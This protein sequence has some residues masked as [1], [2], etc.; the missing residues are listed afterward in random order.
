MTVGQSLPHESAHL[1]VSGRATYVD[2]I[3]QPKDCL[4]VALGLSTQAHAKIIDMDLAEVRAAPGV[5]SVLTAADIPGK[6][7]WGAITHDDPF[8]AIDTVEFFGQAIFMVVARDYTQARQACLLAKIKYE[9][10]TPA[11]TIEQAI[12]LQRFLVPP[13]KLQIGDPHSAMAQATHRAKGC[14]AIGGQEH[15]YL[16]GQ[17]ALAIPKEDGQFEIWSSSQHPTEM[18][19]TVAHVL[20]IDQNCVTS[21]VRR[22]GGGFGG[23]E[24]QPAQFC[25]LAAVAAWHTGKPVKLRL[26]RDDDMM[27]TGKR[28]AFSFD[29]E[30]GFSSEG[31]LQAF[32]VQLNSQCGFSTDY[33]HQVNDR[34]ICHIDNCYHHEHLNLVNYRCKTNTQS[35]TAFRGFGAPQ[36]MFAIEHAMDVIARATGKDPLDVRLNNLY[37]PAPRNKTHYEATIEAFHIPDMLA[38]LVKTSDYRERRQQ[39][40]QWNIQQPLIKRGL[41][42]TPIMFGVSFNA[43]F[44][45][46]GSAQVALYLDGSLMVNHSGTEMGQ[47]LY[48]KVAQVVAHEF[49]V[50][51]DKVRN[52]T[53][54][55]SKLPNTSPTAASSGSDLNGMA[56]QAACLELK[57]RLA[58]LFANLWSCSKEQV[59]FIDGKVLGPLSGSDSAQNLTLAQAA[60]RANFNRVH[61]VAHG[62]Y[63]TPKIHW[64]GAK[65]K[66]QPFYYY[67]LGCACS[68]VEIDTLTGEF[69]LTRVDILHDVGN[70]LNPAID[71]GQIEG[72]FIQG[73]GYLTS[74]EL[75]WDSKGK[76]QTHAPSTY[77]IPTASDQPNI[78]NVE[79]YDQPNSEPTIHRSKAVGEP[80]LM[81]AMSTWFAIADA[82]SSLSSYKQMP[83]LSAPATPE[84]ILKAVRA[85]QA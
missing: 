20:G 69:K 59:E 24:V 81:L 30:V 9:P 31:Q 29:Y 45:N 14:G 58:N 17:V 12:E 84:Q 56:A 22:M 2:D 34:A 39:I 78:F 73:V 64:D 48:T 66:G 28:H 80:P 41:A 5:V 50:T 76:L 8:L 57:S 62:F 72:G 53:T 75:V 19:Q 37:G 11:I 13:V 1:H 10:L 16:E 21:Y 4:F 82:I 70:S 33:S 44:L 55:T 32:D 6:K 85:I 25:G 63:N 42:M 60:Q 47:G 54:D 61:L 49:G 71:I 67:A 15:F 68:E 43:S 51:L 26:D 38:Q 7:L 40:A 79:L 18:Q 83:T 46:R 23:K 65:Y 27:L 77:K 3:P 74:E 52:S 35:A 36:G